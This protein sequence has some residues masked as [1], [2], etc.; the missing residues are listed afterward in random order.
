MKQKII[1]ISAIALLLVL[2]AFMAKDFFFSNSDNSNP[3]KFELD[4]V[5]T[6]D[7]A[8][9]AYTETLK[10]KTSLAEI[11]GIATDLTGKI[12]VAG[13]NGVDIFDSVEN[14]LQNQNA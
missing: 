8:K 11:H 9:P 13:K 6:G 12:Y 4:N 3:Y 2:V 5:R 7:T 14:S 10:F 1:I